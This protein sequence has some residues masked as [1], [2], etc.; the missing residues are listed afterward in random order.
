[1]LIDFAFRTCVIQAIA[2]PI[3]LW[4]MRTFF[5]AINL[6]GRVI[7]SDSHLFLLFAFLSCSYRY[8]TAVPF[9]R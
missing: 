9:Y 1:M 8:V 2:G 3:S 7:P 6:A 5:D 4:F